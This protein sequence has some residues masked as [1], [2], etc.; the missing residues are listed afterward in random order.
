MFETSNL[1]RAEVFFD[2][3]HMAVPASVVEIHPLF[4]ELLIRYA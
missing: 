4:E 2:G 3:I 1:Q